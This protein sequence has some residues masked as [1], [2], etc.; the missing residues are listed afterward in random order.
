MNAHQREIKTLKESNRKL[1]AE[2]KEA[3]DVIKGL[4]MVLDMYENHIKR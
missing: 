2:L 1:R 3:L 4:E